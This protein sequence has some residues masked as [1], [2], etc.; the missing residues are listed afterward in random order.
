[1]NKNVEIGEDKMLN[2]PH[3]DIIEKKAIKNPADELEGILGHVKGKTSVQL[4]REALDA[5]AEI[6]MHYKRNKK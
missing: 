3:R 2:Y 4:K 5:W 1:M 6:A